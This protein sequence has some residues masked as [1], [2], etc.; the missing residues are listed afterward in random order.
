MEKR[1][2]EP[3]GMAGL[4]VSGGAGGT[5]PL[6]CQWMLVQ[7]QTALGHG[8]DA[9]ARL[10]HPCVPAEGQVGGAGGCAAWAVSVCPCP[11]VRAGWPLWLHQG[12][13]MVERPQFWDGRCYF[14][15]LQIY[16]IL[17]PF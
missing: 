3:P 6:K 5:R 16:F 9:A 11:P 1:G 14:S 7:P 12:L 13:R 17:F 8:S 15:V 4:G 10:P 2:A